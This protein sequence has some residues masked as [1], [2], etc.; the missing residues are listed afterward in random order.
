MKRILIVTELAAFLVLAAAALAL[1][2]CSSRKAEYRIGVVPKGL[3]HEFW[4]SI[5]RGADRAA[6]D[7][8][9]E[10]GTVVDIVWD[11]PSKESDAQ[12]Q[13][14]I[15]RQM[16][17]Q[18]IN[19]L[20]LAPQDS[21]AMVP[22]VQECVEKKVPV[23]VIDS[24][25]DASVLK[26]HPDFKTEEVTTTDKGG[27]AI[28]VVHKN[29]TPLI[30]KYVA[31]DNYHG[32]V[33]AAE[34]LVKLLEKEGKA[35]P[36]V[37]LFRY[38]IGSESTDQREQGFLDRIEQFNAAGKKINIVSKDKYAGATVE[39]AEK[40]AGPL[41]RA[42]RDEGIDGIFAVNESAATGMLN[43]LRAQK[44]NQKTDLIGFD[45]SD[46][47]LQAVREGDVKGLIVQDPYRMGYLGV[48]SLIKYLKGFDVNQHHSQLGTGEFYLTKDNIDTDE[49]K[50]KYLPDF[51][52]KRTI[53]RPNY[54]HK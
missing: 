37:I 23:V 16:R 3:T 25:L 4:Q 10:D 27:K 6:A 22:A 13:I 40:E 7:L 24:G 20:V 48:W 18:G 50:G 2:G 46:P 32:G 36:R 34:E 47:L 12:E 44:L 28:E 35:Q 26:D 30:V 1:S 21:K 33:M 9:K 19:G 17:N 15:I 43:A 39:T 52:A 41:L 8:E 42:H 11:G 45:S 38:Q 51:Q 54:P 53:E 31:T 49:M 29:G 14:K 5:H